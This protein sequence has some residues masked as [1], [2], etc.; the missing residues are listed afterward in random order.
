MVRLH[1]LLALCSASL[2]VFA[3]ITVDPMPPLTVC[4]SAT[5]PVAFSTPDVFN[6]GNVFTVEL[7]DASGSFAAPVVIGSAPGTGSG[8]IVC[9]IPLGAG[10]G[11]WAIRVNASDPLQIG[12]AAGVP[13]STVQP[14]NAGT[15]TTLVAC[16]SGVPFDL[17]ALLGGSPDAGGTWAGPAG[18]VD[19]GVFTPGVSM[20]GCY[21]YAVWGFPPCETEASTLCITV[22]LPPNAGTSATVSWCTSYGAMDLFTQLGGNPDAGGTWTD[23]NA[24]GG[25]MGG[26]FIPAGLATGTYTFTYT[27]AGGACP[28]AQAM[29]TVQLSTACLGPPQQDL[30]VE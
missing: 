30:P 26:T 15:N 18:T 7:S 13:V 29:V 1:T 10:G 16:G 2:G 9:T 27:A 28:D 17:F 11:A 19:P 5:V 23:D 20:P 24:T 8:S 6:A 4:G 14:P 12:V 22:A 21:T 25:L 3:Q